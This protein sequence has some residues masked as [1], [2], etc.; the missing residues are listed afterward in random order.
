MGKDVQDQKISNDRP[1]LFVHKY[2]DYIFTYK[3]VEKGKLIKITLTN[4]YSISKAY[5]PFQATDEVTQ[6]NF[7]LSLRIGK[8]ADL[9]E[10]DI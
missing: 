4:R 8:I 2:T 9:K 7:V 3:N 6:N 10:A 5:P 1:E